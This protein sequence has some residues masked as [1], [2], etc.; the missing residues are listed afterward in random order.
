MTSA[1]PVS[2]YPVAPYAV[3]PHTAVPHKLRSHHLLV[4]LVVVLGVLGVLLVGVT[5]LLRPSKPTCGIACYHPPT[6]P[7]VSAAHTWTSSRYHFS[8]GWFDDAGGL[9]APHVATDAADLVLDYG[10]NGVIR[11]AGLPADGRSPE[12]VATQFVTSLGVQAQEA[13]QIPNAQVGY[14]LGFGAAYD[15]AEQSS[16]GSGGQTRLI[17]QV[18]QRG[19]LDILTASEGPYVRFTSGGV[20]DGHPSPADSVIASVA[21]APINSVRWPG[22]PAP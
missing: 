5:I 8:V 10:D 17:V 7:P 13:Y 20:S 3:A 1:Q 9:P 11:F 2:P 14:Q 16:S 6:G 18:A 12:E 19:P 4:V 21:D 15:I 22:D